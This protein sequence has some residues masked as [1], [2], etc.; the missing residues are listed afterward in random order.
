MF[1]AREVPR[2]A[3]N[4]LHGSI[5]VNLPADV[6]GPASTRGNWQKAALVRFELPDRCGEC[7]AFGH[8]FDR[9]ETHIRHF[10]DDI[11]TD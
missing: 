4:E 1:D 2:V 5:A 3:Y 8:F 9:W 7:W 6:Q 10:S 11:A